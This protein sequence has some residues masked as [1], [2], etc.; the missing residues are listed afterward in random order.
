MKTR[1]LIESDVTLTFDSDLWEIESTAPARQAPHIGGGLTGAIVPSDQADALD[2]DTS[3]LLERLQAQPDVISRRLPGLTRKPGTTTRALDRTVAPEVVVELADNESAALLIECEGVFG[4]QFPDETIPLPNTSPSLTRKLGDMAIRQAK[5]IVTPPGESAA[6]TMQ[7]RSILS[8][9]VIGRV[10]A[11]VLKFAAHKAAGAI[12]ERLERDKRTGPVVLSSIDDPSSWQKPSDFSALPLDPTS[13]RVLLFVH[14]TFSSIVGGFGE[15]CET[16]W[17]QALLAAAR[18]QYDAVIGYDHRT[19]SVDPLANAHGLYEAL[20]TLNAPTPPTIDIVCHSRGGLVTRALVEKILPTAMWRP[21]IGR[22]VFAAAANAGTELARPGNWHALIDLMTNLALAGR[23]ALAWVGAPHAGIVAGEL[24]DSI[25]DFVRYLVDAAVAE[26]QVPG[27]AAMDPDGEFVRGINLAEP[28]APRPVECRYYAIESNFQPVMFD[29][30]RHEPKEFPRRLALML[31]N[32]FIDTLMK[33]VGNDLVVHVESMGSIDEVVG[34]YIQAVCN[35]GTNPLVYHTNY[36]V[37][38][39]T[40]DSLAEWLGLAPPGA[41]DAVGEAM[42]DA[43]IVT[44]DAAEPVG[45]ALRAAKERSATYIVIQRPDPRGRGIL[46]Y[47]PTSDEVASETAHHAH[48]PRTPIGKV[49]DLHEWKQSNIVHR[50]AVGHPAQRLESLAAVTSTPPFTRRSVVF[51]GERLI[52]VAPAPG[53]IA[54]I[55]MLA[56]AAMPSQRQTRGRPRSTSTNQSEVLTGTLE[57]PR[58]VSVV[59][60]AR[61]EMP[62]QLAVGSMATVTVTL[63]SDEL[64]PPTSL[65]ISGQAKLVD[66]RPVVIEVIPKLGFELQSAKIEDSRIEFPHPP[67][68]GKPWIVDVNVVATDKGVGEVWAIVRQGPVRA[69]TLILRPQIVEAGTNDRAAALVNSG[70]IG[71]VEDL[72]DV[73]T[74]EI[75][76]QKNG[77]ETRF[78]YHVDIPGVVFNRFESPKITG[79]IMKWVESLYKGIEGAWLGSAGNRDIFHDSLKAKG[80]ELL[81]QLFPSPLKD[82]LWRL[83]SDGKLRSM[84]VR[85]DEPFV[86]WEM[87]YLDDPKSAGDPKGC[88]FGELGL[89][90]WLYGAVPVTR[91]RMRRTRLRYVIPHYPEARYRLAAAETIEEP[92]LVGMQLKRIEPHYPQVK[93]ALAAGGFDLLHFAGHGGAETGNI[94]DAIILLEGSYQS[95]EGTQRYVTEPLSV[96]AVRS[97]ARLRNDD[98]HRPLVVLNACQAGRIGFSLTSIGGFA[99]AFLGARE[100]EGNAIGEAGAFVSSLWSVGDAPASNF[101]KAFYQA[102]NVPG[103]TTIGQAAIAAREAARLAGDATWLAYVIYAHPNCH[104]EFLP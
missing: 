54:A 86:P 72:P 92:M 89:C 19:L 24:V 101:A 27:L 25:G 34:D 56:R 1:Q 32:G 95:I 5:F 45:D 53:E 10:K 51:D 40:V 28:G 11:I 31:A 33:K 8:D 35:Y 102:A 65:T 57:P 83:H 80:T 43:N 26:N 73:A 69:I 66:N 68:T 99:P 44:V 87:A 3:W 93:A 47:A 70:L 62:P 78:R 30:D 103:G 49:L 63:S 60:H 15:L 64:E 46:H 38:P 13:S 94:G 20:C 58:A 4:W 96:D 71:A 6:T 55:E 42:L 9:W 67:A 85:S 48:D 91:I 29:G 81:K 100:G 50:H 88:F 37:Q 41:V 17:G 77:D 18:D 97:N 79:D 2:T 59:C 22:V 61:A 104:I 74:L 39:K 98:G 12:V 16:P 76:Q 75:W 90:R 36:F 21:H 7:Q 82:L 14:G 84:L 23:R 52:G